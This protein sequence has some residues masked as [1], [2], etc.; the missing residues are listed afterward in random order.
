MEANDVTRPFYTASTEKRIVAVGIDSVVAIFFFIPVWI[1]AIGSYLQDQLVAIE[2]RWILASFL[3]TFLYHWLF[4]YFLGGT[5]GKL[6]TGLRVVPA[7]HPQNDLGLMQSFL[8]CLT[9]E[10]SFFFGEALH[11]VAFLRFDR[12][13]VSD[14]VAETRVVQYVPRRRLPVRRKIL[15]LFLIVVTGVNA[16]QGAYQLIQTTTVIDGKVILTGSP[17]VRE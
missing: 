15:A 14:W 1:Q 6:M 9:D 3:M 5:L 13:H 16:F 4:L 12:T 8:R 10:L 2:I 17:D 7:N 11:A